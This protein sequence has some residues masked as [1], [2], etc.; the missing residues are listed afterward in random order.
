M[1]TSS[2]AVVFDTSLAF[3]RDGCRNGNA[4]LS[5]LHEIV[6]SPTTHPHPPDMLQYNPVQLL[7]TPNAQYNKV[8]R[9][10][11]TKAPVLRHLM[12]LNSTFEQQEHKMPS[13]EHIFPNKK[14]SCSF[15]QR[16]LRSTD[17]KRMN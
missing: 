15:C 5:S 4:Q 3:H 14:V 7:L 13:W 9:R 2:P 12:V 17:V 10:S 16:E 6:Y 1:A 11:C 8:A